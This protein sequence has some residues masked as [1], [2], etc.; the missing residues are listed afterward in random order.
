MDQRSARKQIYDCFPEIT[1][2]RSRRIPTGSDN[3][4]LQINGEYIFRFPKFLESEKRLKIEI[5]LLSKIRG[6]LSIPVPDYTLVWKTSRKYPRSFAGYP[7]LKGVPVSNRSLGSKT[8]SRLATQISSLLKE[9]H[10]IRTKPNT[11]PIPKYTPKTW[12]RFISKHHDQIRKTVYPLLHHHQRVASE[13]L[14][15]S[16]LAEL[17]NA[18]FTPRL[19]HGDLGTENILYNPLTGKL[20]GVIDWGFAQVSDPALEFSHL[21]HHNP[22]LARETL[23]RYGRTSEDFERRL[24]WYIRTEPYYDV[25]WGISNNWKKGK[26]DGLR[27]L[28][29][30]L[31]QPG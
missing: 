20:T 12:V 30:L 8:R 9:L 17:A 5:A 14:W 1:V 3:L 31:K 24:R 21:Y 18:H 15:R 2:R 4:V 10:N 16:F 27:S 7:R 28:N 26:F 22:K 25:M 29:N 19:I 6:N 13:L 11:L 23:N